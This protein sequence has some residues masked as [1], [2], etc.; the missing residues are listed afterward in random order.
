MSTVLRRGAASPQVLALQQALLGAGFDPGK[1]DGQFGAGTEAAVL[2]F[3]GSELM[4]TDGVAGPRTLH[5]LG[6]AGPSH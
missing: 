2:A 4:L 6:L 3:Q 5:R 1:L